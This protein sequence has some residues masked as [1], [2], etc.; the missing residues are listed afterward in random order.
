MFST[1]GGV[2]SVPAWLRWDIRPPSLRLHPHVAVPGDRESSDIPAWGIVVPW[3]GNESS[4]GAE[5]LYLHELSFTGINWHS[6]VYISL[7]WVYEPGSLPKT[8]QL[9]RTPKIQLLEHQSYQ[10]KATRGSTSQLTFL[11]IS[12]QCCPFS[13]STAMTRICWVSAICWTLLK[14]VSGAKEVLGNIP[15]SKVSITYFGEKRYVHVNN[16]SVRLCKAIYLFVPMDRYH[17]H[18][19]I[20]VMCSL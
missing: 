5:E 10:K 14:A 6:D 2:S 15:A 20:R 19:L 8:C 7:S 17:N 3:L 4:S 13:T 9:L 1:E 12:T 18:G 16:E 11:G